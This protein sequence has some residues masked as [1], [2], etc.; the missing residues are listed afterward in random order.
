[1]PW[2]FAAISTGFFEVADDQVTLTVETLEMSGD[3]DVDRARSAIGVAAAREERPGR[4]D[5][6]RCDLGHE[7]LAAE[8]R[9]DGHHH[10]D[11]EP[12]GVGLER[13]ERRPGPEREARPPARLADRPE[14]RLDRLLDLHVEGDR[15]A[16][17]REVVREPAARL[18]DHQ[19]RVE[20]EVGRTPERR[21]RSRPEGEVRDEAGIH[22][23][24]VDPVGPGVGGTE[25]L[26]TLSH[27][28]R[29]DRATGASEYGINAAVAEGREVLDHQV[30]A[31]GAGAEDD[32]DL[33]AV[34]VRHLEARVR[35]RLLCGDE[36]EEL[37]GVGGLDAA[38]GR[39]RGDDLPAERLG[40][41]QAARER[42]G[43][44]HEERVVQ[45]DQ[46]LGGDVGD[47]P[48][49]GADSAG[50]GIEDLERRSGWCTPRDAW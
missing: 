45:G 25:D 43:G 1:M 35:E 18:G 33:L 20:R 5:L 6:R 28:P 15:V 32:R 50:R 23:V 31:A 47:G 42:L 26:Q 40:R 3:V 29:I 38:L 21:D 22:H 46:R 41:A 19:V 27:V 2:G 7:R 8:P 24:E 11:V 16:A 14:G 49:G 34:R 9:L 30:L 13:R 4:P 36:P 17:G 48:P 44:L 39:Y 10:H 12:L 37:R